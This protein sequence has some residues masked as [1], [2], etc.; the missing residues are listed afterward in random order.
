MNGEEWQQFQRL[1][2][3]VASSPAFPSS[4]CRQRPCLRT[5]Y[6]TVY[7]S[8]RWQQSHCAAFEGLIPPD[9]QTQLSFPQMFM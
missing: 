2:G 8:F 5:L 4:F 9:V 6:I 3:V 7:C 1:S